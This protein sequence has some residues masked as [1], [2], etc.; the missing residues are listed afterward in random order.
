MPGNLTPQPHRSANSRRQS[1]YITRI[2]FDNLPKPILSPPP[3][4][5]PS[6]SA[7]SSESASL[8][9]SDSQLSI[10]DTET[11]VTS[12]YDSVSRHLDNLRHLR[13]DTRAKHELGSQ[14]KPEGGKHNLKAYSLGQTLPTA[15]S[16]QGLGISN[17]P[18]NNYQDDLFDSV[19]GLMQD[20]GEAIGSSTNPSPMS[21]PD[22]RKQGFK[23]QP[24]Q[25]SLPALPSSPLQEDEAASSSSN[26]HQDGALSSQKGE[27]R[28]QDSIQRPPRPARRGQR[29]NASTPSPDIATPQLSGTVTPQ[30]PGTSVVGSEVT[31]NE[32]T[33]SDPI[34]R[35]PA[36]PASNVRPVKPSSPSVPA[37]QANIPAPAPV[38]NRAPTTLSMFSKQLSGLAS[39]FKSAKTFGKQQQQKQVDIDDDIRVRLPR[40]EVDEN[41]L[42]ELIMSCAD[43]KHT[44]R[45]EKDAEN[46]RKVGLKL[47]EGWREQVC[48]DSLT[49]QLVGSSVLTIT[50]V[51]RSCQ[52]RRRFDLVSSSLRIR[53]KTSRMK[54]NT[55]DCSLARCQSKLS[56]VR[57][58]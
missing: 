12:D 52:K 22:V 23:T 42:T 40:R 19:R 1:T 8:S 27:S 58:T 16:H 18:G 33:V 34:H 37:G 25:H 50:L 24:P 6:L 21:S 48:L 15:E 53:W 9:A 10:T 13:V 54:T 46:L 45:T 36:S 11:D 4:V 32:A 20:I 26:Q 49:F 55:C 3:S 43:A 30:V 28:R 41:R 5:D 35:D 44:L 14:L 38:A 7:S 57:K 47:E 2:N 56:C 17:F 39:G 51:S 31:S 29:L